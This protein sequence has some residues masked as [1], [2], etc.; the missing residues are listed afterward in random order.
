M[1]MSTQ[2]QTAARANSF[3]VAAGRRRCLKF[4]RRILDLS[5]KV[6]AMHIAPA[7]SCLEMVDAAYFGLMRRDARGATP[8]TFILSKGHGCM[9][10]YA[11]LE[12]LGT[13]S[14]DD[15][16]A[17]CT[18]GGIL[19]GHPDYGIP[20]IEAATGS[21]GHGLSIA[22]GMAYADRIRGDDRR[23]FVVVGDGEMHE[24]SIWEAMLMAPN[25]RLENLVVLLDLNDFQ[26][27]DRISEGHPNFYPMVDKVAAFGWEV[28]ELNGHDESAI[29]EAVMSR[30][31]GRPFF[32]IGRA[33]KGRGVAFM[34]NVPIWHYRSPSPEEYR[35]A[36][37]NLREVGS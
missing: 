37:A 28:V 1:T 31:G 15:L 24:G 32:A 8:D 25:L 22:V 9:A 6:S 34:E 2:T 29:V 33:V 21:L 5:Q 13:L 20:G 14:A 11:V 18:P 10:Q 7:F 36:I 26:G 27:L 16:E 19:G 23:V 35:E 17:Y 3:D 4:R 30:R 12:E